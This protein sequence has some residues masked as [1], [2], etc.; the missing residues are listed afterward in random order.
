MSTDLLGIIAG[1]RDVHRAATTIHGTRW[2]KIYASLMGDLRNMQDNPKHAGKSVLS[3]CIEVAKNS[4][5]V[6]ARIMWLATAYEHS[7]ASQPTDS[8]TKGTK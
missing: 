5:T 7:T 8:E 2:P 1:L 6:G 4:P 3:L